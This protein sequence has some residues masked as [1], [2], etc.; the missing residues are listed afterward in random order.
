MCAFPSLAAIFSVS[1][2]R[3]GCVRYL[4][5]DISICAM[6]LQIISSKHNIVAGV[7]FQTF[8]ND[9]D[10]RLPATSHFDARLPMFFSYLTGRIL[11][12]VLSQPRPIV[13]S[14][15]HDRGS[16]SLILKIPFNCRSSW[17]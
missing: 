14:P 11:L 9:I 16:L 7:A 6:S 15:P 2:F 3:S 8:T 12:P 13:T 17:P 10:S 4:R 1:E 5:I